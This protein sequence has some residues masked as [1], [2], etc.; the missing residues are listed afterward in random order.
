MRPAVPIRICTANALLFTLSLLFLAGCAGLGE[1]SPR[2]TVSK[3]SSEADD[4][5]LADS[6]LNADSL[7][8]AASVYEKALKASP[9]SLAA[10]LGLG[11]V[12]YRTG[13][14]ERARLIFL[15][16]EQLAPKQIEPKIGLARVEIRKRHLDEAIAIYHTALAIQ[17]DNSEA[18]A[19]LGT[20]L[21]LQGH[22][23]QA[24]AIY[25]QALL[26]HPE[27][28][29]VRIDLGLSLVLAQKPREGIDILLDVANLQDAPPEARQD[30]ALAFGVLGNTEAAKQ[31]LMRDLP[32]VNV[33]DN[34]L[35]Y[36]A[37][38][39]AYGENPA[40]APVTHPIPPASDATTKNVEP[41]QTQ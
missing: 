25:R 38:R 1:G 28:Q 30:L 5:R 7:Q 19:G 34:L 2:A 15:E 11:E 22:H 33:N 18:A 31:I 16:A 39:K 36:A 29:N 23:D 41:S 14:M 4:L 37:I 3:A 24:Q 6:A 20:A 40:I 9:N 35:F 13:D 17:P 12:A 10:T 32:P 27:A 21:D 8:M 26:A